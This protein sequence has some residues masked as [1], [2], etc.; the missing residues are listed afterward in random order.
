MEQESNRPYQDY[1]SLSQILI[2]AIN[3]R[4]FVVSVIIGCIIISTICKIGGIIHSKFVEPHNK[5]KVHRDNFAQQSAIFFHAIITSVASYLM[6]FK[7]TFRPIEELE[8]LPETDPDFF[9][10]KLYRISTVV[11]ISYFM[12]SIPYELL[13]YDQPILHRILMI[14]HHTIALLAQAGCYLTNPLIAYVASFGFQTEFSSLFLTLTCFGRAAD[15]KNVYFIAGLGTM[16]F[17]P[18]TRI[19]FLAITICRTYELRSNFISHGGV[20]TFYFVGFL[21]Q[22]FVLLMSTVYSYMLLSKPRKLLFLSG[23]K[24]T[25]RQAETDSLLPKHEV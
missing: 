17:Y 11:S 1:S 22:I 12:V 19:G 13:W 15:S 24:D 10:V 2:A 18:L 3:D 5:H 16:I 23:T 14:I 25:V 4:S 21:G 20:D 7:F 6:L 8:N 9:Y